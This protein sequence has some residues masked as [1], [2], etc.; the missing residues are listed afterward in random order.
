MLGATLFLQTAIAGGAADGVERLQRLLPATCVSLA[1]AKVNVTLSAEW[2]S[3]IGAT[4]ACPLTK[5][6]GEKA[7]IWLVSVFIEDYYRDKPADAPWED[8][9]KPVLLNVVGQQVGTLEALFPNE[10]PGEMVLT[11]G[12]WQGNT[13]G[14]IKTRMLHPGVSGNYDLPTL[15]WNK[16][17]GRYESRNSANRTPLG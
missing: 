13:P 14:E 17:L 15:R 3:Y 5:N 4:R 12:R 11:Y 8:F 10:S 1:A 2:K 9:P 6:N 7:D 16:A